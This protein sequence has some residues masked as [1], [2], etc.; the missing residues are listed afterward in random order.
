M[1]GVMQRT[2]EDRQDDL[3]GLSGWVSYCG[4]P[5]P[6]RGW[7]WSGKTSREL[8][9]TWRMSDSQRLKKLEDWSVPD[10]GEQ[11]MRHGTEVRKRM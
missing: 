1:C 9:K 10:Q 2:T 6:N 5:D 8:T 4:S 7:W 3:G 11:S